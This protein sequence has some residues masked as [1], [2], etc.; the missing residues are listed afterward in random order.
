MTIVALVLATLLVV[1]LIPVQLSFAARWPSEQPNK[2]AVRWCFGLIRHEKTLPAGDRPTQSASKGRAK[3]TTPDRKPFP[4]AAL[5]AQRRFRARLYRLASRLWHAIDKDAIRVS[6]RVGTGDPAE[7]GR[8][9]A[10]VGPLSGWLQTLESYQIDV[11]PDFDRPVVEG[12][13]SGTLGFAPL[14]L[15]APLV[16]FACSPALWQ[17]VARARR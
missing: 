7:T 10:I 3:R 6:V 1:L 5:V 8:L 14:R 12:T 9:W 11:L 15:L 2:I 17:S 13:A 16:A 4:V